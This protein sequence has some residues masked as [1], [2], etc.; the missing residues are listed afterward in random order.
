MVGLGLILLGFS[1]MVL[2]STC[3]SG[4]EL[5]QVM[6]SPLAMNQAEMHTFMAVCMATSYSARVCI[7]VL[8]KNRSELTVTRELTR[9]SSTNYHTL[10]VEMDNHAILRFPWSR[11]TILT[12]IGKHMRSMVKF[13]KAYSARDCRERLYN[14]AVAL[15]SLMHTNPPALVTI[16]HSTCIDFF[17]ISYA[18]LPLRQVSPYS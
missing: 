10:E 2:T 18:Y 5:A 7:G 3:M 15:F 17:T 16:H 9:F 4:R 14:V 6:F 1:P 13:S 12:K 11:G 8:I